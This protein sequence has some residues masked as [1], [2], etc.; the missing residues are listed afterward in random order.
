MTEPSATTGDVN[1]TALEEKAI[2]QDAAGMTEGEKEL[3]N[4]EQIGARVGDDPV[5]GVEQTRN[6]IGELLVPYPQLVAVSADGGTAMVTPQGAATHTMVPNESVS[7]LRR[8]LNA[9]EGIPRDVLDFF[10]V[11]FGHHAE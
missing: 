4:D 3:A 10:A 5:A 9:I 7:E 2:E 8:L 1:N 6:G 11:H